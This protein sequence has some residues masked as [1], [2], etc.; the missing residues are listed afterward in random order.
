MNQ[1]QHAESDR[2][3][4]RF[5]RDPDAGIAR[6]LCSTIQQIA[7]CLDEENFASFLTYLSDDMRYKITA[8]SAELR[9]EVAFLDLERQGLEALV[10]GIADHVRFP[11]KLIRHVSQP[12]LLEVSEGHVSS[13]T[14][15]TVYHIDPQGVAGLYAIGNYQDRF[16]LLDDA[17]PRLLSRN[18]ALETRTLPFGSHIP[19]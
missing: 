8:F 18:V 3:A 1:D 2:H 19:L 12:M 7:Y 5:I 16:E 9:K 6:R 11:N 10:N 15:V 17:G 14:K 4:L 13:I